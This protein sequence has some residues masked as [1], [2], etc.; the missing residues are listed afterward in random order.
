[1]R[2]IG[3]TMTGEDGMTLLYVPAGEF[4]MGSDDGSSDE[5]PVHTVTLDAFW[6]DRT[7][8]TNKMYSQ[9]VEAGVCE[10][11]TNT[12][13]FRR[14]SY[15]G[16]S[17]FD[18]YPVI[19]VNWN[20]AK[21]YCEWADRRL[22]TEAEWEKVARGENA[23]VYPWGNNAPN[24]NLLNFQSAVGDTTEVGTYPDGAS[25]Y[26]AYDMAGNVWEWVNDWY[27]ETYYSSSP[28]SNPEGPDSGQ[29]RVL[30]GGAWSHYQN[31]VRSALRLSLDPSY[32]YLDVGFRC[33]RSA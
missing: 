17:N 29:Y 18:N 14:S 7:E 32:S 30:R 1:M 33:S 8:V 26:G 24:N 28:A 22:P 21:T 25:I 19:Y 6:I 31:V 23:S 16:N 20:M 2:G 9:C 27:S 11:P 10:E 5:K 15:Y 13:S 3:S 12:N 4:T